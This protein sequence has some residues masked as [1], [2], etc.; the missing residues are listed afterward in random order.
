MKKGQLTGGEYITAFDAVGPDK[1]DLHFPAKECR[2]FP[3]SGL[4][5]IK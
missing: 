5:F 4:V 3:D 2:I 1:K